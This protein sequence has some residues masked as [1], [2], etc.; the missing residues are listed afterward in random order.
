MRRVRIGC[1]FLGCSILI[2]LGQQLW[3]NAQW[4]TNT[5]VYRGHSC[6][7]DLCHVRILLLLQW[8]RDC[9]PVPYTSLIGG[10]A[11]PQH[12]FNDSGVAILS[13]LGVVCHFFLD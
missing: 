3:V 6:N 10:I 9:V 5:V 4:V 7:H 1:C 8:G 12:T 13:L 2:Q 11:F